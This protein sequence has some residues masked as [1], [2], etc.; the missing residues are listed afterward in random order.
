MTIKPIKEIIVGSS[1]FFGCMKGFR[2]K[3]V[4]RLCI[5][6]A[7]PF[8]GKTNVFHTQDDK[9]DYILYRNMG[10]E[11]YIKDALDSKEPLRLGKFLVPEFIEYVG[12]KINDLKRLAPLVDKL[13]WTHGYERIIF[14]SYIENGRFELTPEQRELAYVEYKKYR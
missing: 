14:Q 7:F 4:D 6:N 9:D 13:D 2:S 1:A 5:L 10:K 3:D 11:G 8:G 12:L